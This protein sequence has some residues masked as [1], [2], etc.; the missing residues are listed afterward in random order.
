MSQIQHTD[1]RLRKP[2]RNQFFFETQC[3]DQLLPQSHAARV[4]WA[5]V[6]SLDLTDFYAPIRARDGLAGRDATDP[7]LLVGLWLLATQRGVGSAREL[8]RLC[9]DHRVFRWMCGG[10]SINHH[11]LSDFRVQHADALDKL[12]TQVLVGL[13]AK[14][15][16]KVSRITQDGTRVRACVGGQT[17]RRKGSLTQLQ[18][19][20]AEH[21][22]TL[23]DLLDDPAMS[24]ELSARKKAA[25][26]RAAKDKQRRLDEALQEIPKLAQTFAESARRES[27]KTFKTEDEIRVSHT[28]ASTRMMKM[29]DGSYRPAHN[30]Q[31]AADPDSRAIV[32]VDVSASGQDTALG[33]PMRKQ[34]Q[35]RTGQKVEEHIADSGYANIQ[36][37]DQAERDGVTMYVPPKKSNGNSKSKDKNISPYVPKRKDT[38]AIKAWRIRMGTEQAKEKLRLRS[39]TIETINADGKAHR[40]LG[41]VL[42]RGLQKVKCHALWFGLAYNLMHFGSALIS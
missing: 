39:S 8:E 7:R 33:E 1:V 40:G 3:L 26:L 6:E 17:F 10:V 37:I 25:R 31:L 22:K 16:V 28:D 5:V 19:E 13:I 20:A 32:G 11:L 27:R 30:I 2:E 29:S 36:Q 9:K 41:K 12:F 42:V 34:V 14:K 35:D 4:L 38:P 15:L 18:H 24:A 23:R 21:V